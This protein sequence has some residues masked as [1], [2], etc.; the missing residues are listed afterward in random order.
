MS[1]CSVKLSSIVNKK[2]SLVPNKENSAI[3]QISITICRKKIHLRIISKQ[4]K[5]IIDLTNFRI[6]VLEKFFFSLL[7]QLQYY[8]LEYYQL[9]LLHCISNSDHFLNSYDIINDVHSIS[10]LNSLPNESKHFLSYSIVISLHQNVCNQ[11]QWVLSFLDTH[12]LPT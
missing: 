4:P 3:S 2:I 10:Q 12:L 1:S 5:I 7:L 8:F 6:W 9:F 11:F